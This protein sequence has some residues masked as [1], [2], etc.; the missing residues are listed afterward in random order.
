M[1]SLL[2][3]RTDSST[4]STPRTGSGARPLWLALALLL[5]VARPSRTHAAPHDLTPGLVNVSSAPAART[6]RGDAR[7]TLQ[8]PPR[9]SGTAMDRM[10]NELR[11]LP[12]IRR[13]GRIFAPSLSLRPEEL[14]T[15]YGL[16]TR[17]LLQALRAAAGG[18]R[19]L[20]VSSKPV[21]HVVRSYYYGLFAENS[22]IRHQLSFLTARDGGAE[23]LSDTLLKQ[24]DK[25]ACM[26]EFA[27]SVPSVLETYNATMR[28]WAIA[29]AVGAPLNGLRPEQADWS[30]KDG[31]FKLFDAAGV[32]RLSSTPKVHDVGALAVHIDALMQR[33]PEA[34][35]WMLKHCISSSGKGNAV[36][37]VPADYDRANPP[38]AR[39]AL[40][41]RALDRG[42]AE[43]AYQGT[44]WEAYK[45]E[46]REVGIVAERFVNAKFAPS[47]QGVVYPDGSFDTR[48][49]H[50]QLFIDP[51]D[52]DAFATQGSRYRGG[53]FPAP[54]EVR[55]QLLAQG[56]LLAAE[57]ARRGIYGSFGMDAVVT[58]DRAA[59]AAEQFALEAN[60]RYVGPNGANDLLRALVPGHLTPEGEWES[61]ASGKAKSY[62]TVDRAVDLEVLRGLS[63]AQVISFIQRA[64]LAFDRNG[65]RG[66]VLH[67]LT[68]PAVNGQLGMTAYGDGADDAIELFRA[69]AR[70]LTDGAQAKRPRTLN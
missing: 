67:M 56:E 24:P 63:P 49:T 10:Q 38:A 44:N 58:E 18:N 48:S 26:Q 23:P 37:R 46:A 13:E 21:P 12:P 36:F 27:Q 40:L 5:G 29:A 14:D 45:A 6:A 55:Q 59:R 11:Q 15:P 54:A 70:A 1:P 43:L 33:E 34:T 3:L 17:Q 30:S 22:G 51:D 28:E 7:A 42:D 69:G 53:L 65:E 62:V 66:I 32:K 61:R 64:G 50:L 60:F 35:A 4:R 8:F 16:E 41:R 2:P 57:L 19:V 31:G 52:P 25:L 47:Y 9:V 20:F 68:M 39:Q